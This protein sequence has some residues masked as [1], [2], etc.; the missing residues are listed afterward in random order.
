MRRGAPLERLGDRHR[1]RRDLGT[2]WAT[3]GRAGHD[4]NIQVGVE[5]V[6]AVDVGVVVADL[7][8][9]VRG[10]RHGECRGSSTAPRRAA[11]TPRS[12]ATS[13]LRWGKSMRCGVR[14]AEILQVR[15]RDSIRRR[16]YDRRPCAPRSAVTSSPRHAT[17]ARGRTRR[18][19]PRCG[20]RG[21][22]DKPD[23]PCGRCSTPGDPHPV[24]I[25]IPKRLRRGLAGLLV[26]DDHRP[27]APPTSV[28]S[29][30]PT[31]TAGRGDGP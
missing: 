26:G 18:G 1:V 5:V 10:R 19:R 27:G 2:R 6:A 3:L 21:H 8:A 4:V 12:I 20:V 29:C 24:P 25:S 14:L 15:F 16:G 28:G 31:T 23:P 13:K 11:F 30:M 17:A 7:Q 9:G 22:R